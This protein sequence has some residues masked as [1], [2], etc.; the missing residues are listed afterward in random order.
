[1]TL[2][3]SSV[4]RKGVWVPTT[5]PCSCQPCP[6]LMGLTWKKRVLTALLG[7]AAALGLTTLILL[8]VEATS[9]LLPAD[10][11]VRPRTLAGGRGGGR[12]EDVLAPVLLTLLSLSV[13]DRV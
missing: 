10:T 4:C 9:V 3:G 2:Q 13:W 1:M 6:A 12:A 8:L 5:A 11:K 7:A